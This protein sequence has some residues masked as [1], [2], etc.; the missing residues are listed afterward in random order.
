M[1]LDRSLVTS[2]LDELLS[3]DDDQRI[4]ELDGGEFL[5]ED[6]YEDWTAPTRERVRSTVAS[7][8]RRHLAAIEADGHVDSPEA[9]RLAARHDELATHW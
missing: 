5:P 3:T 7:A 1:A 2:D 9:I 8:I 4:I 6:R